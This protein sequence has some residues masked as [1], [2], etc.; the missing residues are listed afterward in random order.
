[1]T[2]ALCFK[3]G[4]TKFGALCP[5][6][7][8]QSA[9]SGNIDLDIAFSDHWMSP[10]TL[11]AFGEVIRAIG[12][13]CDDE[14]VRFHAFLHYVSTQHPEILQIDLDPVAQSVCNELLIRAN[15]PPV[16]VEPSPRMP[17]APEQNADEAPSA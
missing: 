7:A 5:C 14:E 15:P 4:A 2:W 16:T 1:M 8:C 17:Q 11:E 12:R 13:V 9:A 6:A 3:C 10:A